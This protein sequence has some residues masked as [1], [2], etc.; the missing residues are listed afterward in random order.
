MINRSQESGRN[1][2]P[3]RLKQPLRIGEGLELQHVAARVA[4]EQA[5]LLVGIALVS[6]MQRVSGVW[7]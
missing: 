6:H 7:G 5:R 3:L 4:Y 2:S 1:P